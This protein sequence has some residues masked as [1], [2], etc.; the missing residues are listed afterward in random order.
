MNRIGSQTHVLGCFLT[1]ALLTASS[2]F[3]QGSGAN[4]E[5][6]QKLAALKQ[7]VIQNQQALHRY[8]WTETQETILKGETKSSKHFQCQ[9]GPDG[10]V[11]KTVLSSSPAPQKERGLKG[12][13]IEKK[14]GEMQDYMERVASL[15]QRYVPPASSSMQDSFQAGKSSIQPSENGIVMIA[16][17]DY[18]KPG[19][20]VTL[21]FDTVTKKVRSYNVN[22]YLDSPDDVVTLKVVF[23]SLPD[24]TNYSAQTVLDATVKQVQIRTTSSGYTKL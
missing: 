19:D 23:D 21:A 17:R 16:F 4:P 8:T 5:L 20:A 12:R 18:A 2:L 10:K 7:S 1:V 22:T 11:Q 13:V 3:S 14:K 9:Y 24:G 6:Q 15:I